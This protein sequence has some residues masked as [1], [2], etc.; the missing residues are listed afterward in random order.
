VKGYISASWRRPK[1]ATLPTSL[2][3]QPMH[4]LWAEPHNT[5][6]HAA[7]LAD[8]W[9]SRPPDRRRHLEAPTLIQ[10]RMNAAVEGIIDAGAPFVE[11]HKLSAKLMASVLPSQVGRRMSGAEAAELIR[12][13]ES[14]RKPEK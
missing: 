4:Q 12:W 9:Q 5:V 8:L 14:R 7:L 11:G 3:G 13:L 6:D 2:H 1:A 10:A